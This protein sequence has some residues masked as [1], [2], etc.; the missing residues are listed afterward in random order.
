MVRPGSDM[1]RKVR[2]DTPCAL[3]HII[4]RG[5][6]RRR[7]IFEDSADSEDFLA[8]IGS[9]LGGHTQV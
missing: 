2:I 9:E 1:P 5:I 7:R 4:A 8:R 6:Q 3:H